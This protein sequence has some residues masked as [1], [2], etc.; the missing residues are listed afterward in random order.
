MPIVVQI[1]AYDP[2]L[3]GTVTLRMASDDDASVCHLNGQTWWPV[4]DRL[5]LLAM[6]FFGGEFGQVTTAAASMSLAV[7]PWPNFARY[8]FPDA[9]LQIWHGDYNAAWAGYTL[10]FDGRVTAQPV[11][12]DGRAQLGFAVDDKW[13][14]VPL[15]STYAGTG[16]V[17][18]PAASKGTPKPLAIGAPMGVSGVMLDPIKSI[19]Q[20]SA[21]GTI[22]SVD[23]PLER[24]ARQFGSAQ[25]DY[26]NYAALDAATVPA[27]QW[28]TCKASGLVRMGAPPY[29]KLCFLMKGD[30]GGPDAWV[31]R[32]GAIIKRLAGIAGG[33][34]KVSE[35][36]VDALDTARPYDISLYYDGQISAREAIQDIAASVNAVA[37]VSLTG[38]LIT[39]PV[40]INATGLTYKADGSTIPMLSSVRSLGISA[41]WWRLAIGAQPFWDVHGQGDYVALQITAKYPDPPPEVMQDGGIYIDATNKQFRYIGP[42]VFSDEGEIFSDEGIASSSGYEDIQD[43][44]IVAAQAAADAAAAAAAAGL[45]AAAAAQSD[46]NDAI[47]RLVE[48]DD[49]DLLTID[50]K[51]RIL[52][53]ADA[54]LESAYS[55]LVA[56]AAV[57]GVSSAA[58]TTARSTW[59]SLRNALSPAWNDLTAD[60]DIVRSTFDTALVGYQSAINALNTAIVE[61]I[62]AAKQVT[63]TMSPDKTVPA[64]YLGAV[65]SGNLSLL[66]WSPVVIRGGTSIKI[67]NDAQ[68]AISDTYGGTFAVSAT[69]GASDKGDITI[70]A[71]TSGE[72]GGYLT[73]TV[74]GV[75]LPKLGFKVTKDVA[76]PPTP[77]SGTDSESWATGEFLS[78]SGTSYTAISS[79]KTL[80]LTSGQSLYGTAP[81]DYYVD[82]T[83]A[84][85]RTM[86]AKW[87]YA[88]AGSGSWNDFGSGIT[89]SLATSGRYLPNDE[90][91][92][93]NPGSVAVTQTKSG[94]S[95]GN[96]DVR[97]VG[98]LSATGRTVYMY[99]SA[100]ME[101]KT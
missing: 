56:S 42:T 74:N 17:E 77:P 30:K 37:G 14:D 22:E 55:I 54:K 69:N 73:V 47:D 2:V 10:R 51:F 92:D 36:A 99:G 65:T 49:D 76:A 33:S 93:P 13:L 85:N 1:D 96:Y 52:I 21:Y 20:L 3:P 101:A 38:Q 95:A 97:L 58:L 90:W 40:Q 71:I 28:A 41:P 50:E 80:T 63:A 43:V 15:L 23:V 68:Y 19:I 70:S 9:R 44:A 18:G 26:A 72:A 62:T 32:P 94:L 81:L 59:Q 27:G 88:V 31:R 89:G 84:A 11:V 8:A 100:L 87:Q 25:A 60:T 67:S 4:L 45:A 79:V 78:L 98:L 83:T 53:P 35:A 7:E 86:T 34:A 75:A 5:P 66:R 12:E 46:A 6:D 91:V 57:A 48:L 29:G 16:G 39:I 61:A 24:L 82:G 64:D